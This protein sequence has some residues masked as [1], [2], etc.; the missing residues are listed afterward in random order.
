MQPVK[1]REL[2]IFSFFQKFTYKQLIYSFIILAA[3]AL[4]FFVVWIF[5]KQDREIK[6]AQATSLSQIAFST[7]NSK[8]RAYLY[9]TSKITSTKQQTTTCGSDA[10]KDIVI[11]NYGVLVVKDWFAGLRKTYSYNLGNLTFTPGQDKYWNGDLRKG[12]AGKF[13]LYQYQSCSETR[14][15]NFDINPSTDKLELSQSIVPVK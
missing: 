12:D 7:G 10:G 9:P 1:K 4:I 14:A 15:F 3:G 2:K 11:G 5:V 13:T 6:R 8:A